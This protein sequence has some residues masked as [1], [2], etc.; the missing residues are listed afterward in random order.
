M[1]KM[2]GTGPE[3]KGSGT[4]RKLGKCS[5]LTAEE[6][7]RKLGKG[8]GKR[9]ISGGGEGKGKRLKSGIL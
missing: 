5:N 7:L 2:D 9:H 8:M 3:G 1:P 4:G 6:K